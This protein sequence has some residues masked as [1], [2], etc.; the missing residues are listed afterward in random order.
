L[1]LTLLNIAYYV[2]WKCRYKVSTKQ[3]NG[4]TYIEFSYCCIRSNTLIFCTIIFFTFQAQSLFKQAVASLSF[5]P[6]YVS[7][8]KQAVL[9]L[10]PPFHFLL[11]PK[12]SAI[13]DYPFLYLPFEYKAP[14]F[15]QWTVQYWFFFWLWMSYTGI[16]ACL[17]HLLLARLMPPDAPYTKL[18]KNSWHESLAT[19]NQFISLVIDLAFHC[20]LSILTWPT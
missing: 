7:H 19:S 4:I 3:N 10:L 1:R 18:Q 8:S 15:Y 17:S 16:L 5:L 13:F 11:S 2:Q 9:F 20:A 14:C 6:C 12:R